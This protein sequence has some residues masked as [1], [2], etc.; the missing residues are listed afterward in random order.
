MTISYISI[1]TGLVVTKFYV[2]PPR[3]KLTKIVHMIN[4]VKAFISLLRNHERWP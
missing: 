3:A 2:G 1:A 4:M